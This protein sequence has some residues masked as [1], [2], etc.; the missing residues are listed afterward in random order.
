V[1][2][3]LLLY[4]FD[5]PTALDIESVSGN[6]ELWLPD[7]ASF[8][9]AHETTSGRLIS[10]FSMKNLSDRYVCG[11]GKASFHVETVSGNLILTQN[12]DT[13]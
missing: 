8:T 3:D 2:G 1:S 4:S 10:D 13:D 11:E 6:V 9:L 5:C 7:S 12:N